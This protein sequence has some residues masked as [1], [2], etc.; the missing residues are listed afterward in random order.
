M[1][2]DI[3]AKLRA[4]A[5]HNVEEWDAAMALVGATNEDEIRCL[6]AAAI[7]TP[8]HAV[9]I[10]TLFAT[11]RGKVFTQKISTVKVANGVEAPAHSNGKFSVD[12]LICL[13]ARTADSKRYLQRWGRWWRIQ[14]G[15]SNGTQYMLQSVY[16]KNNKREEPKT[17]VELLII[18]KLGD[19]QYNVVNVV[20]APCSV[21]DIPA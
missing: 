4:G 15:Y 10:S 9:L 6:M 5:I 1:I 19:L 14:R 12:D 11:W 18:G 21:E 16:G 2:D 20:K 8:Q 13:E 7:K 3:I 17:K